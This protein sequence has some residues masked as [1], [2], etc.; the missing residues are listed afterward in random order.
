MRIVITGANGF[1]GRNLG[2]RLRELGYDDVRAIT[3]ESSSEGY[4]RRCAAPTSCFTWPALTVQRSL[5]TSTLEMLASA[6]NSVRRFATP[7]AARQLPL[8]HR[9]RRSSTTLT[10]AAS[11]QPKTCCCATAA[12]WAFRS[13]CSV[14]PTCSGNGRGLTTTLRWPRSAIRSPEGLRVTVHDPATPLRLVYVDDVVA[15]FT[16]LLASPR[17]ASGFADVGPVYE[18]TV[19][20]LAE[21]LHAFVAS[22]E[23]LTTPRVGTGLLRALNAT[24]LSFL[25]LSSFDYLVPQHGDPRGV[26]VEM[27]KTQ[28]AASSHTSQRIPALRVAATIT[29]VRPKSSLSSRAQPISVFATSRPTKGTS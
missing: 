16:S 20:E 23:T 6:P 4:G 18:I 2:V 21:T 5:P 7:I 11:A 26:F 1:I 13:I 17:T 10:A 12:T 8:H 14:S 29:T 22:R 15:A 19:G 24:F 27:L 9:L 28:T 3:R 25:P